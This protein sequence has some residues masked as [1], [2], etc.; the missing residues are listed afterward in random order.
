MQIIALRDQEMISGMT[1][2]ALAFEF[3]ADP[4]DEPNI[5]LVTLDHNGYPR[6]L[7]VE[8]ASLARKMPEGTVL[9]GDIRAAEERVLA[10]DVGPPRHLKY[11]AEVKIAFDAITKVR[12]ELADLANGITL[13]IN[14]GLVNDDD[15]PRVATQQALSRALRKVREIHV[16]AT[17]R[18]PPWEP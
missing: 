2:I 11:D 7:Q 4:R 14:T 10:K 5:V 1:A 16:A 17:G 6:W 3:G 9:A 12:E 15:S 8:R 13:A 18:E